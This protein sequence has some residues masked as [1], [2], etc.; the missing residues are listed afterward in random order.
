M[1]MKYGSPNILEEA[2]GTITLT[3]SQLAALG[4]GEA[5]TLEW[6]E[7]WT[8]NQEFI[9]DTYPDFNVNDSSTWPDF[10]NL[11]DPDTWWDLLF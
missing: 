7:F 9:S 2:T 11:A 8:E 4:V 1:K 3:V 10:F 5:Q 6:E